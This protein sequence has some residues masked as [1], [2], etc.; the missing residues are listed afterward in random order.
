MGK[1]DE[2]DALMEMR[3]VPV[4]FGPLRGANGNA[5]LTGPCGDTMEYWLIIVENQIVYATFTTD[6]CHHSVVCGNAAVQ[7]VMGETL[8][9]IAQF[10]MQDVLK[11]AAEEVPS[12]SQHCGLLAIN[13]VKAAIHDYLKHHVSQGR[14][15]SCAASS[16]REIDKEGKEE[17]KDEAMKLENSLAK[18]R[19][20]IVVMSGKG[21]VG[22]STVAV[23]LAMSLVKKG[24]KVGILDVDIHGPSVPTMLGLV[25]ES[26]QTSEGGFMPVQRGNLS[27]MSIGFLLRHQ[28]NAII[29]RG[30][31]KVS[32]IRQFMEDVK[33]GDLDYLVVDCPPGT[34]DEPLSICQLL[35]EIN[36][37]IIV[38]TPQEVALADVR[39]SISFCQSLN[40]PILGIVENMSGFVCPHCGTVT[41]IFN[42]GGGERLAE[43]SDISYIGSIPIDPSVGISGDDGTPFIIRFEKSNTAQ[44]FAPITE[45]A[46]NL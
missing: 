34:G 40:L 12:E 11:K 27:V 18:I 20:K 25:H 4:H 43:S 13:T 3:A 2:D 23:N 26:L 42:K 37:A 33:W 46:L 14:S 6:G 22:K 45:K 16:R 28:D 5:R 36:G 35:G 8:E 1:A 30:P 19:K 10:E 24:K 32:A 39:K 44:L 17:A 38:T 41:D 21:G 9:R 29:W 15:R 31:K 7:L